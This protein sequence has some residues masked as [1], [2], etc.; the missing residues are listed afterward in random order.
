MERWC[1]S[2]YVKAAIFVGIFFYLLLVWGI[3]AV[4]GQDIQVQRH[5]RVFA[6]DSTSVEDITLRTEYHL[7]V[8]VERT[9]SLVFGGVEGEP[10]PRMTAAVAGFNEYEGSNLCFTIDEVDGVTPPSMIGVRA[11]F[12]YDREADTM[13]PINDPD[14][15]V[16]ED[17]GLDHRAT[18]NAPHPDNARRT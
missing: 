12:V 1:P 17:C 9:V 4:H 3:L 14:G 16:M 10:A 15:L 13:A 6:L 7:L 11:C 2:I 8:G 18:P 5:Y